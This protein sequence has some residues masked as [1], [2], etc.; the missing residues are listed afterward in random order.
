MPGRE[1][2]K[3]VERRYCMDTGNKYAHGRPGELISTH[4]AC[5]VLG[6]QRHRH[7]EFIGSRQERSVPMTRA[8]P[9]RLRR[10]PNSRSGTRSD[11][12]S[13]MDSYFGWMKSARLRFRAVTPSLSDVEDDPASESCS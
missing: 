3:L 7:R 8:Q 11:I 1:R 2:R 9:S 4:E 10:E 12:K 13:D 5:R 6:R